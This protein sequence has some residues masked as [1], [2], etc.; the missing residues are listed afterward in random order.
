MELIIA[1]ITYSLLILAVTIFLTIPFSSWLACRVGAIDLPGEIKVH[2]QPT[3]RLGGLGILLAFL[4][5]LSGLL[6]IADLPVPALVQRQLLVS[7]SLLFCLAI[8]G[9]LDDVRNLNPKLRLVFQGIIG[10]IIVLS[11]V[12]TEMSWIVLAIAWFWVVGLTNAYNFLDGLDGLAAGIAV[13]N[14]LALGVM[15][16]ISGNEL[17][18]I[19][20]VTLALAT[21]GFLRYNWPPASIFMGDIGSLSLGFVIST[22]SLLLL[23]NDNFSVKA[24]LAVILAASLPFGDLVATVLRRLINNKPLFQ[25]DRGHFYDL[26]VD[27]AG[28]SAANAMRLSLLFTLVISSLGVIVYCL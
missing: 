27:K 28:L 1:G 10:V 16:Y 18:A 6:A 25:G 12:D 24:L 23:L 11:L 8:L 17:L 9:F 21:C 4:L 20:A 19:V 26:L 15:L 14:L 7:F 22:L 3:P 5:S 13:V 2:S